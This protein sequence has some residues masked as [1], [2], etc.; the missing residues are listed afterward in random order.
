MSL[1]KDLSAVL[2]VPTQTADKETATDSSSKFAAKARGISS[3]VKDAAKVILLTL[4]YKQNPVTLTLIVFH[5][6]WC[7]YFAFSC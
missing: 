3:V 7:K 6:K 2:K 4:S 5:L 1:M